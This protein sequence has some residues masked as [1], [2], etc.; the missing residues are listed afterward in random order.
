M[1]VEGTDERL[2]HFSEQKACETIVSAES[3]DLPTPAQN[4]AIRQKLNFPRSPRKSLILHLSSDGFSF[5]KSRLLLAAGHCGTSLYVN[6]TF[7]L[8]SRPLH[9]RLF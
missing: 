9:S 4:L 1:V 3:E 2:D 7:P 5:T 8:H 6:H